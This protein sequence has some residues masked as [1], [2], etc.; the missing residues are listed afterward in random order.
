MVVIVGC[1]VTGRGFDP[2]LGFFDLLFFFSLPFSLLL[3]FFPVMFAPP[4][5]CLN[6]FSLISIH[7]NWEWL[8]S[9]H[10]LS[11]L[12]C[13]NVAQNVRTQPSNCWY[14]FAA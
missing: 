14:I 7:I 12:C 5:Q 13:T 11:Q 9:L 6:I 2:A 4:L 3:S 10:S 1:R 8:H